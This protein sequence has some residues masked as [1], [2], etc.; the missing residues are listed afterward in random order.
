MRNFSRSLLLVGSI[1]LMGGLAACG[2]DVT[3]SPPT[4]PT[5]KVTSVTVAPSPA[6]VRVGNTLQLTASVTADSG[7]TP[8]VAWTTSDASI[9]SVDGSGKVT[10]VKPG[11]VAITATASANGSSASGSATVTVSNTTN[12]ANITLNPT[13]VTLTVGNT[14]GINATVNLDP[15]STST[16]RGVTWSS[17]NDAVATVDANGVVTAV[18]AGSATITAAAKADPNATATATVTVRNP[19]PTSISVQSITV[20]GNLNQTVNVNNVAGSIDVTL[21]VDPGENIVTKVE[22]LLDGNVVC[23]QNFSAAQ[24]QALAAAAVNAATAPVPVVCQINTAQFNGTSGIADFFNGTHQLSARAITSTGSQVATPSTQLVFN[25]VSGF[26][27]AVTSVN[28]NGAVNAV[29]PRTGLSWIGGDVTISL[30]PVSYVQGQT[31]TNVTIAGGTGLFGKS[32]LAPALGA[33]GQFAV[34]LTN[35]PTTPWTATNTSLYNYVTPCGTVT[36][37]AEPFTIASSVVTGGG[38]GST[39]ILNFGANPLGNATVTALPAVRYDGAAPGVTPVNPGAPAAVAITTGNAPIWVNATSS[40]TAGSFGLPTQATL[41][42]G[43]GTNVTPG[44]DAGVDAVTATVFAGPATAAVFGTPASATNCD[45]TGLSAVTTGNQLAETIVS[46][47]Y[48]ARVQ[49]ADALGNAQC[50]DI[51][52]IDANGNLFTTFGA[53]F[54]APTGTVTGPAANSAFT[55][56]GAVTNFAVTATDNASGF[57]NTPLQV[58]VSRFYPG[59]T[60]CVYGNGAGCVNPSAQPLTFNVTTGATG[61]AEGYYSTTV[62]LVDQAGNIASVFAS[63]TTLVD[64]QAP[65]FNGGISLQS[66][67]AGNA[68]A[69]FMATAIDNIDLQSL[70]GTLTYP[71]AAIQYGTQVIGSYGLPFETS[72]PVTYTINSFIRCINAAGDFATATNVPTSFAFRVFDQAL[73]STALAQAIPGANVVGCGTGSPAGAG[74][75]GDVAINTFDQN[76]PGYPGGAT[77]VSLNGTTASTPTTVT[78]SAVAD[79]PLNTSNNPFNRVEFYWFDAVNGAYRLAGTATAALQQTQTNRT[80]TYT[81][82]W[83]PA[84]PI[85]VGT[86]TVVGIGVDAQGDAVLT[87][88]QTVTIVP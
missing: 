13:A 57:S 60:E 14:Q 23:S 2:D 72:V 1:A 50:V 18:S 12:V 42:S 82:T 35:D 83:D 8:T 43:S 30:L 52:T 84:A 9:A 79:V 11:Q 37:C 39:Q 21:N 70:I 56:T 80:W 88:T 59:T 15:S 19:A 24:N 17:S 32:S 53:D 7:A 46:T 47:S 29:D 55:S 66:L 73:N 65:N 54:T 81:F 68:P 69:N 40:L 71:T 61:T 48:R 41:N 20:T 26:V 16:D 75:V 33:N 4:Q 86:V 67:Y 45:V 51:T 76:A 64:A 28:A 5:P 22:V 3:V 38:S 77:Q 31:F 27:A 34:T 6:Q 58:Q 85:P 49:Y 44:T 10:G 36:T 74:A 87:S 63:R 78:L 62:N 25:N